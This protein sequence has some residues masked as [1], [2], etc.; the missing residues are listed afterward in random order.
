MA[1]TTGKETE[2]EPILINSLQVH[3]KKWGLEGWAQSFCLSLARWHLFGSV[4]LN[5]WVMNPSEDQ[6]TLSQ[7]S[8][9]REPPYQIFILFI[10]EAKLQFWSDNTS[11][12]LSWGITTTWG[13]VHT[14][15]GRLRTAVLDHCFLSCLCPSSCSDLLFVSVIW[16]LFVHGC[17]RYFSFTLLCT[18]C[19]AFC[20][21]LV[22]IY[23]LRKVQK[24]KSKRMLTAMKRRKQG[25]ALTSSVVGM[26]F[27]FLNKT[28]E[29]WWWGGVQPQSW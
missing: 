26:F 1:L 10:A 27:F 7:R 3:S 14:A 13:A 11:K 5:P 6:T 15:F 25:S 21:L 24:A 8:H 28:S 23:S 19:F 17:Q 29:S 9:I 20:C 18:P 22:L 16:F 2:A 4:L 12:F